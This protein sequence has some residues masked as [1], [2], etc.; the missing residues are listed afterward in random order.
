[1]LN[2][3]LALAFVAG[4]DL[5]S[6]HEC[7]Y[8]HAVTHVTETLINDERVMLLCSPCARGTEWPWVA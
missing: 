4:A 3:V 2:L 1:M 8:C 6:V 5:S 7:E